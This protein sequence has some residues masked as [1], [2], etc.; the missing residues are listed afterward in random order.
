MESV[1]YFPFSRLK[2]CLL[3][4]RYANAISFTYLR[5][6]IQKELVSWSSHYSC[7]HVICSHFQVAMM[8]ES[9]IEM[10]EWPYSEQYLELAL[11]KIEYDKKWSSWRT[12]L[13]FKRKKYFLTKKKWVSFKWSKFLTLKNLTFCLP[14]GAKMAVLSDERKKSLL[15]RSFCRDRKREKR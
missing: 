15:F 9:I 12:K 5:N 7:L 13:K 3:C 10:C 6:L 11:S 1:L 2:S 14:N 4:R 8:K